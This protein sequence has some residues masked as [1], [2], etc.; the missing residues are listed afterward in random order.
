MDKP[1]DNNEFPHKVSGK[2]RITQLLHEKAAWL[3]SYCWAFYF[4][5]INTYMIWSHK[6]VRALYFKCMCNIKLLTDNYVYP[7]TTWFFSHINPFQVPWHGLWKCFLFIGR[8]T[9]TQNKL[10]SR[11]QLCLGLVYRYGENKY[12]H[13]K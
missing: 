1:R 12:M 4:A 5:I 6:V 10:N 2:F 11:V 9:K 8:Y 7:I 13:V 3:F